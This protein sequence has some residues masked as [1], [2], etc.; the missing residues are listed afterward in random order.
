MAKFHVEFQRYFQLNKGGFYAIYLL[1][2]HNNSNNDNNNASNNNNK[3]E[4]AVATV[5]VVVVVSAV[6]PPPSTQKSY[7]LSTAMTAMGSVVY[8][9]HR[10]KNT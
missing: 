5:I 6:P 9:S 7:I 2:Q 10:I 8:N 4:E 3:I 1:S